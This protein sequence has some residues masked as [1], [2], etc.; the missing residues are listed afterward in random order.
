MRAKAMLRRP[1]VVLIC[2]ATPTG[3]LNVVD[4]STSRRATMR[5]GRFVIPFDSI[6]ESIPRLPM[7]FFV[8]SFSAPSVF[9]IH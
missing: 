4:M 7:F 3:M 5:L 9:I 1:D 6:R 2:P 8:L